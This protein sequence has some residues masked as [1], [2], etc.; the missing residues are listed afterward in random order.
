MVYI[1]LVTSHIFEIAEAH[2]A[3]GIE[4]MES[5]SISPLQIIYAWISLT[6]VATLI[7]FVRIAEIYDKAGT[8]HIL[9]F[10]QNRIHFHTLPYTSHRQYRM[11][12]DPEFFWFQYISTYL[13]WAKRLCLS[14]KSIKS[15]CSWRRSI[16][17]TCDHSWSTA[18]S[19][20]WFYWFS[21]IH[22]QF[23]L[24]WVSTPITQVR[25]VAENSLGWSGLK[26]EHDFANENHIKRMRVKEKDDHPSL[27]LSRLWNDFRS[28]LSP[29]AG[30]RKVNFEEKNVARIYLSHKK[31]DM[32][33]Y[34]YLN[35]NKMSTEYSNSI[36]PFSNSGFW[37]R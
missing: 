14:S 33:F 16:W 37:Q 11:R 29:G 23:I 32:H 5:I 3:A 24:R 25:D 2:L 12:F 31:L 28:L 4:I 21:S 18:A 15:F 17:T 9:G 36:G 35:W 8:Q 6:F 20:V 13:W 19:L 7:T 10:T 34:W 1:I 30:T 26:K 27:L 22:T